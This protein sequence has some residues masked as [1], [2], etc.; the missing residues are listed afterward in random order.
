M[1]RYV[2][3]TILTAFLLC[4]CATPS[5]WR[6]EQELRELLPGAEVA[7]TDIPAP[8]AA[9][10]VRAVRDCKAQYPAAVQYIKSIKTD[11]AVSQRQ[12]FPI[13]AYAVTYMAMLSPYNSILLNDARLQSLTSV[14]KQY[15]T[16]VWL[17]LHPAVPRNSE[18]YALMMHEFAHVLTANLRLQDN[19]EIIKL[20]QVFQME[21]LKG[22]EFASCASLNVL[23]FIA[24]AFVD[25]VCNGDKAQGM[26]KAVLEAIKKVQGGGNG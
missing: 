13:E 24:E 22:L 10:I 16:D 8:V 7:L 14:R 18:M 6:Q 4:A 11:Y 25:A 20:Y 17:G 26:S 23:E 19:V 21:T 12:T 1:M 3:T 15:A 5:P 9:E 2:L